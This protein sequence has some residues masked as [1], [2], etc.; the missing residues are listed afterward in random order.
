VNFS[1]NKALELILGVMALSFVTL[2]LVGGPIND[3]L[4]QAEDQIEEETSSSPTVQIDSPAELAGI[5]KLSMDRAAECTSVSAHPYP[6]L[7]DTKIGRNPNC[8]LGLPGENIIRDKS[9]GGGLLS[10]QPLGPGND[11]EGVDSRIRFNITQDMTLRTDKEYGSPVDSDGAWWNSGEGVFTLTGVSDKKY[12]DTITQDCNTIAEPN[13]RTSRYVGATYGYIL[14]L[15]IESSGRYISS[16]SHKLITNDVG[17]KRT[18]GVYCSILRDTQRSAA[19]EL[20]LIPYSSKPGFTKVKL[21]DGDKG[22]VQV[23][24]KK[25][26]KTAETEDTGENL[27]GTPLFGYIQITESSGSCRVNDPIRPYEEDADDPSYSG[28]LFMVELNIDNWPA[29]SSQEEYRP[30]DILN[31]QQVQ[32][33]AHRTTA[34]MRRLAD[35]SPRRGP[36]TDPVKQIPDDKCAVGLTERGPA[37]GAPYQARYT[38]IREGVT[39][40][41]ED[42]LPEKSSWSFPNSWRESTLLSP[43]VQRLKENSGSKAWQ[44]YQKLKNEGFDGSKVR[45]SSLT[46]SGDASGDL[47]L[48]RESGHFLELY[49]PVLCGYETENGEVVDASSSGA[50][51]Q[52]HLCLHDDATSGGNPTNGVQVAD[53]DRAVKECKDGS[54]ETV[55]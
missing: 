50:R 26:Y 36:D 9:G 14:T 24:K 25:P 16:G 54:W 15:P 28:D 20:H 34:G 37:V 1:I 10:A 49:G 13:I 27:G 31:N 42:G 38:L 47:I 32:E 48:E 53:G 18:G 55:D 39:I 33:F 5:A 35:R 44:L 3:F 40:D 51:A 7:E 22:Y 30:L 45:R 4:N 8:Q 46:D 19:M 6:D 21:C 11:M 12:S 52:W 43:G 23:N 41:S 17:Y 2:A 29:P